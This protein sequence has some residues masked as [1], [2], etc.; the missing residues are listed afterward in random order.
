M[1]R[2]LSATHGGR[3]V[4]D[5][6]LLGCMI[7]GSAL[8]LGCAAPEPEPTVADAKEKAAVSG[9]L[10]FKDA[11][12]DMREAV[13]VSKLQDTG[14]IQQGAGEAASID[15]SVL[16]SKHGTRSAGAGFARI[17]V[18]TAGVQYGPRT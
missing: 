18:G 7:L 6:R 15:R 2:K 13:D 1:G 12:A 17:S 8:A 5:Y 11:F 14:A 10:A 16:T 9:L 4:H 3:E